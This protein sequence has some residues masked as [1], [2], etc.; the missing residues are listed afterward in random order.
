LSFNL[1]A[2]AFQSSNAFWNAGAMN[3]G[4]EAIIADLAHKLVAMATSLQRSAKRSDR[5]CKS[6]PISTNP[7]NLANIFPVHP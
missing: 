2:S 3:E 6:A 7:E 1:F 5:L 4:G